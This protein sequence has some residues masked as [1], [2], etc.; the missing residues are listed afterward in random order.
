LEALQFN[1]GDKGHHRLNLV[2]AA[3]LLMHRGLASGFVRL[4]WEAREARAMYKAGQYWAGTSLPFSFLWWR[5][6]AQI[7]KQRTACTTER[8]VAEE[9]IQA[10]A[11]DDPI[12]VRR[13]LKLCPDAAQGGAGGSLP[14]IAWAVREDRIK[15]LQVLVRHNSGERCEWGDGWS[16]LTYAARHGSVG[17]LACLLS[18]PGVDVNRPTT[19]GRVAL[20]E[21]AKG[22][23]LPSIQAIIDNRRLHPACWSTHP[24]QLDVENP[25]GRTPLIEACLAGSSGVVEELV[26]ANC[27]PDYETGN[28][29]WGLAAASAMG[30][31][32][33]VRLLLQLG[34]DSNQKSL[35]APQASGSALSQALWG[36]HEE[37]AELL[38]SFG[39]E[40]GQ[41]PDNYG[42][43][44]GGN[45]GERNHAAV[46]KKWI[47]PNAKRFMD[48]GAFSPTPMCA[49]VSLEG[50]CGEHGHTK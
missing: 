3:S 9:L 40:G 15:A 34:A 1:A 33:V 19:T 17:A 10:V 21:A 36:G 48:E 31:V 18:I 14:A 30:H 45:F 28:G 50:Q 4:L 47:S 24:T 23:H 27:D 20:I 49:P 37:V 5:R 2:H 25:Q 6:E 43:H 42:P 35:R 13:L 29:V 46:F 38:V 41:F 32:E 8:R 7:W 26:C 11:I 44:S 22:N 12:E 39:A 16:P